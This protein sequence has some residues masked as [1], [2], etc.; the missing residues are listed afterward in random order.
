MRIISQDG[1]YDIPYE[2]CNLE[3]AVTERN[4]RTEICCYANSHARCMAIYST[5]E[6]ALKA[7]EMLHQKYLLHEKLKGGYSWVLPKVFQF[8]QNS[9][10]DA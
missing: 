2:T 7:M 4:G 9:E 6:K 5:R 1:Y 3:I 8:P 10:V